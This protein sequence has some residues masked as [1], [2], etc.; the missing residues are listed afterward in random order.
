MLNGVFHTDIGKIN[1]DEDFEKLIKNIEENNSQK[2]IVFFDNIERLG[3]SSLNVLK[4]IQKLS[5]F[6]FF[7]FIFP[8][9][10]EKL[11]NIAHGISGGIQGGEFPINKFINLSYF[12]LENNFID[13]MKNNGFSDEFSIIINSFIVHESSENKLTIRQVKN[14]FDH[15][16]LSDLYED[17]GSFVFVSQFCELIKQHN[18][19]GVEKYLTGF[20]NVFFHSFE[21]QRIIFNKEAKTLDN[22]GIF[23]IIPKDLRNELIIQF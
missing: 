3:S 1:E 14:I 20:L 10:Y 19:I 15:N 5:S 6:N 4:A 22:K 13:L 8:V 7:C 21:E 17:R 18:K 16:K 23:K 2:T 12:K 9:Y 11:N